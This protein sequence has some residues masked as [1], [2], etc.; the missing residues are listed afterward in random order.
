MTSKAWIRGRLSLCRP[1]VGKANV[2]YCSEQ[3][4]LQID[5]IYKKLT[6]R[7]ENSNSTIAEINMALEALELITPL[8]ENDVATKSYNLFRVVMHPPPGAVHLE[9]RKWEA[10]R[11]ALHGAYKQDKFLPLVGDPQDI[12]AFLTY[13]FG[14]EARG[15]KQD[16]PIRDALRALGCVSNPVMK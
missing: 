16:E 1:F 3:I 10:R 7:F 9:D 14:L 2:V 4:R 12:L 8:S 13:H 11:L 15:K 5:H 6:T